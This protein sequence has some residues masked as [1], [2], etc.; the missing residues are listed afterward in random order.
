MYKMG[1]YMF[2]F[3]LGATFLLASHGCIGNDSCTCNVQLDSCAC[4]LT[5]AD[6]TLTVEVKEKYVKFPLGSDRIT[7]HYVINN[8]TVSYYEIPDYVAVEHFENGKWMPLRSKT[9]DKEM[10]VLKEGGLVKNVKPYEENKVDSFFLMPN[11]FFFEPG[12]YRAKITFEHERVYTESDDLF[13]FLGRSGKKVVCTSEFMIADTIPEED[14]ESMQ[15]PDCYC[16]KR[17]QAI[18]NWRVGKDSV[19][20]VKNEQPELKLPIT[21]K[22]VYNLFIENHT[23]NIYLHRPFQDFCIERLV[24]KSWEPL[25]LKGSAPPKSGSEEDL[26]DNKV[27]WNSLMERGVFFYPGE[28]VLYYQPMGHAFT[29]K[30]SL[31]DHQY[32]KGRYRFSITFWKVRKKP[33]SPR[34]LWFEK[35][36]EKETH[37]AEFEIVE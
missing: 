8:R 4:H 5:E 18:E 15:Q 2:S 13:S 19:I 9:G 12:K 17:L 1:Y 34:D 7:L 29:T 32:S 24:G 30:Y 10:L 6:T 20:T 36:G 21:S 35:T 14:H 31:F 26:L 27:F 16:P 28:K 22:M 25:P 3:L 37:Y 33:D 11:R 23:A